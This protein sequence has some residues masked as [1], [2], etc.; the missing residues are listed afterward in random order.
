MGKKPGGFLINPERSA[1][2]DLK[3]PRIRSFFRNSEARALFTILAVHQHGSWT[4]KTGRSLSWRFHSSVSI[5]RRYK[6][7]KPFGVKHLLDRSVKDI[8]VRDLYMFRCEFVASI[9][10]DRACQ[11]QSMKG[12]E[13][14]RE[15]TEL[16]VWRI[17]SLRHLVH[18]TMSCG[19]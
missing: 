14:S 7:E 11:G 5:H 15:V 6:F 13:F 2:D 3:Y 10:V 19:T 9:T 16:K 18:P 17:P 12:A 4:I 8:F 1:L